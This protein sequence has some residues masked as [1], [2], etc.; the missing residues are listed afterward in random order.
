MSSNAVGAKQISIP[1]SN[2]GTWWWEC[3]KFEVVIVCFAQQSFSILSIIGQSNQPT[4]E[5]APSTSQWPLWI[6]QRH[7]ICS[8]PTK[9]QPANCD[10]FYIH[11]TLPDG[12]DTFG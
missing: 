10:L 4:F 7:D 11:K 3:A 12:G 1:L 2:P 8:A 9:Y 6:T 5:T